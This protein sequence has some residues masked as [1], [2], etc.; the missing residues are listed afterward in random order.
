MIVSM[1]AE[2]AAR[3]SVLGNGNDAVPA[4][5]ML[6]GSDNRAENSAWQSLKF[7]IR[8]RLGKVHT[9]HYGLIHID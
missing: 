4:H 6:N 1:G 3:Y 9:V 5:R 8:H 7:G 2:L